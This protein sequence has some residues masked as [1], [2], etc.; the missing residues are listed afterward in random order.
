MILVALR[1]LQYRRRRF[2]ISVLAVALV[3][4]LSLVYTGLALSFDLEID[5]TLEQLD[6]SGYVVS[7]NASGPFFSVAPLP[8]SRAAEVASKPGVTD[9]T[10]I[11]MRPLNS[12]IPSRKG[13]NVFGVD[14]DHVGR[15]VLVA[16]RQPTGDRDAV[17]DDR[18]GWAIGTKFTM[19]GAE[20]EVVGLTHNSS[21][22]AG[23][24]NVFVTLRGLQQ[25]SVA[26]AP[27][28]TAIAVKGTPTD[29]APD[30]KV[31]DLAGTHEDLLYPIAAARSSI[32]LTM[33]LLWIV[34]GAILGS[35][36]FL[37]ANERT[38]EFAAFKAMGIANRSVVTS[39]ILQATLTA[40]VSVAVA[41]VIGFA[42]APV[43]PVPV[44][45]PLKAIAIVVLVGL[46]IGALTSLAAVRRALTV[47]PAL[48]FG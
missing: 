3:F 27:V 7:T 41:V 15:P 35:V 23:R 18:T 46:L 11:M 9:A 21:L 28:A 6:A 32:V 45:I 47:D 42:L 10:P 1:D 30:L 13:L 17:V 8:E 25:I 33:I 22:L 16:G 38:S 12:E 14:T 31:V 24:P 44:E 40:L 19:S 34:A 5:R 39:L 48:A 4:G 43:F 36:V 26:G 20:F 29:L 2:L 37:S